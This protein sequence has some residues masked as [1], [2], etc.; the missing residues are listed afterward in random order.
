MQGLLCSAITQTAQ[1]RPSEYPGHGLIVYTNTCA[2]RHIATVRIHEPFWGVQ[3]VFYFLCFR[4][5]K[6]HLDIITC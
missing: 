1:F 5:T 6:H 4:I 3:K 2:C